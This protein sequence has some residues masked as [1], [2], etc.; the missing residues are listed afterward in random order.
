MSDRLVNNTKQAERAYA[1]HPCTQLFPP[2]SPEEE[3]DFFA[4]I[5]RNGL[6]EAIIVDQHNRIVDGVHRY[7]ACVKLGVKPTF[8]QR[9]LTD[10]EAWAFSFSLNFHRRHMSEATRAAVSAEARKSAN[11]PLTQ[12]ETAKAFNVSEHTLRS[13]E[14]VF[15]ASPERAFGSDHPEVAHN[16][17]GLAA[18]YA[19]TS[20][21]NEA[22]AL[23]RRALEIYEH[24]LG[25]DHPAVA[26]NFNGLAALYA[27]NVA[28]E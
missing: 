9:T 25:R 14:A 12:A 6:R 8:D 7:R 5:E 17:T 21:P 15:D 27:Q 2:M 1:P 23:Y 20:R 16:F 10:Q 11:L 19:N 4:D 22:E 13:A 18:L 3:V 24:A 28:N 26:H